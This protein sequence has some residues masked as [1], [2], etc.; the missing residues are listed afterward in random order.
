MR[1]RKHKRDYNKGKNGWVSGNA[2]YDRRNPDRKRGMGKA[3]SPR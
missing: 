1:T 2:R 3:T